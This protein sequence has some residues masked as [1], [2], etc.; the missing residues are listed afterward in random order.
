[1]RTV[2]LVLAANVVVL[3][4]TERDTAMRLSWVPLLMAFLALRKM[5]EAPRG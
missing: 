3:M 2:Y 5:H 4:A 1:M